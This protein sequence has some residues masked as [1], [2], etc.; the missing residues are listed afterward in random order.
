[1]LSSIDTLNTIIYMCPHQHIKHHLHVVLHQHI[2]HYLHVMLHQHIKRYLHVVLHQHNKR[3]LHVVLHQ[4]IKHHL[5]GGHTSISTKLQT[6]FLSVN[7]CIINMN[8]YD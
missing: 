4:H 8:M 7:V 3:Y 5:Q 2:K 6:D 1:M